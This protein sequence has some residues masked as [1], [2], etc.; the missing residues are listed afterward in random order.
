MENQ[1]LNRDLL[2][3]DGTLQ[4]WYGILDREYT[5]TMSDD[6]DVQVSAIQLTKTQNDRL[7]ALGNSE[8]SI[9]KLFAENKKAKL[10]CCKVTKKDSTNKYWTLLTVNQYKE[11]FG[12]EPTE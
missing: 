1:N 8:T 10:V 11:R 5:R 3:D 12:K 2:N 7:T 4:R 6:T 9:D